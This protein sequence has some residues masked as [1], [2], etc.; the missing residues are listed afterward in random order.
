MSLHNHS[1]KGAA[2]DLIADFCKERQGRLKLVKGSE[3]KR[4][5][6]R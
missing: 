4:M 3:I 2:A 6:E 5:T 1:F